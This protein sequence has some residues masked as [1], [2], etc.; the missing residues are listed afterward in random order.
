L[1]LI[2]DLNYEDEFINIVNDFIA[3]KKSNI[4]NP[5]NEEKNLYISDPLVQ[6]QHRYQLNKHIKSILKKR[7]HYSSSRN[8]AINSQDLNLYITNKENKSLNSVSHKQFDASN[9]LN[10][11]NNNNFDR[12]FIVN[13]NIAKCRYVYKAYGKSGYN[14]QKCK[15]K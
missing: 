12:S 15:S 2:L 9:T 10:E 4:D 6:K 13:E 8:S 7:S 11:K 14:I 1:N 5:N 3:C